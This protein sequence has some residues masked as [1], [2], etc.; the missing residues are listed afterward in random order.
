MHCPQSNQ[1][2]PERGK[3]RIFIV[4]PAN[5]LTLFPVSESVRAP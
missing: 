3:I 1:E 5:A 4:D 2:I